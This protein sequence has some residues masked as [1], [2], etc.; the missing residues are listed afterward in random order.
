MTTERE[1]HISIA[2]SLEAI[3]EIL[4]DNGL[5][6]VAE[7]ELRKAKATQYLEQQAAQRDGV[8]PGIEAAAALRF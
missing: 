7:F 4:V 1:A 6:T 8:D 3:V 5:A 2:A